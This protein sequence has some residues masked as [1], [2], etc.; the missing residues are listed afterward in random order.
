MLAAL[1][2]ARLSGINAAIKRRPLTA[3]IVA[4]GAKAAVAD[5]MVQVLVEQR[6]KVDVRRVALF[7]CFGASYQGCFQYG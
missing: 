4:T 2:R 3:A 1:V 5:L 6:E 7:G